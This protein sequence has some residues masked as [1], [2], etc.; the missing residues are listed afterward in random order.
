MNEEKA[1][2]LWLDIGGI[3]E[4]FLDELE[5]TAGNIAEKVK[6]R[7]RRV[8]YGALVATAATV[9]AAVAIIMLKPKLA[10]EFVQTITGKLKF[11]QKA[12]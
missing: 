7:R 5:E 11:A 6:T 1:I 8:K 10:T 9:S 4:L 3:N 2:R 12:A